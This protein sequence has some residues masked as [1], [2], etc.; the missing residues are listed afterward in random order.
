MNTRTSP[1]ASPL[2]RLFNDPL[3][4][5]G[6]S[7]LFALSVLGLALFAQY[8]EGAHPCHLCLYQRVPYIL[9]AALAMIA[10]VRPVLARMLLAAIAVAFAVNAGIAIYHTGVEQ[11]WWESGVCGGI[12]MS[13]SVDDVLARIQSAPVTKC[14]QI[15]WRFFGLSMANW[16]VIVCA[17]ATVICTR[18]VIRR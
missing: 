9:I 17:I 14:D 13:G 6:A 5:A 10:F 11:Y 4:V 7:G 3:W 12:D 18:A 16:N 8:V 2:S 1:F 15:A